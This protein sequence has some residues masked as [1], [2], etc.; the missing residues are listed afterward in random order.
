MKVHPSISSSPRCRRYKAPPEPAGFF[1]AEILAP[2]S[3]SR[4]LLTVTAALAA[5]GALPPQVIA[6]TEPLSRCTKFPISLR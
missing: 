2:L 6:A 4:R 5:I 1:M 3:L